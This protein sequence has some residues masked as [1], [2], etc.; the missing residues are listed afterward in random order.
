MGV[1]TLLEMVMR[2]SM[3]QTLLVGTACGGTLGLLPGF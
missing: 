2:R 1:K 3:L